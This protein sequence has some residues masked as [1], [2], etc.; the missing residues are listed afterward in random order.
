MTILKDLEAA[1]AHAQRGDVPAATRL[2]RRVLARDKAQP[3]ANYFL[4]RFL[5]EAGDAAASIGHFDR[6]AASRPDDPAIHYHRALALVDL[7]RD[8]EA[9]EA[10]RTVTRLD[11]ASPQ[12]HRD[13]GAALA[14]SGQLAAAVLSLDNCVALDRRDAHALLMLAT[15]NQML[16][17]F[18]AAEA[19][20]GRAIAVEPRRPEAHVAHGNALSALGRLADAQAAFE[21]AL[22]IDPQ[23][24]GALTCLVSIHDD[25]GRFAT[26]IEMGRRVRAMLAPNFTLITR[27]GDAYAHFGDA[28]AAIECYEAAGALPG[29]EPRARAAA[30]S[31][32]LRARL[33]HDRDDAASLAA[34]HRAWDDMHGKPAR[35]FTRPFAN[36][37]A[38]ERRL[39]VGYVSPDFRRHAVSIFFLPFLGAHDRAGFDI[40]CYSDWHR[41][42]ENTETIRGLSNLFR[43]VHAV[44][45]DAL[46]DMIRHDGIDILVDLAGHQPSSRML[47]FASKPAPVQVS[48]LGYP[49]TTGLSAIDWR[50]SDAVCDPPE[51]DALSSE[52]V[53]R[54]P[55]FHA[56]VGPVEDLPV[57]PLPGANGPLTFG[58]FNYLAKLSDTTLR[59]WAR[60]LAAVPGSRL[61]L[62]GS[63]AVDEP[64]RAMYRAR[65]VAAGL[66]EDRFEIVPRSPTVIEHL[67][68]Y[69]KIDIALDPAPYCGTTTTCEALWM[70]VPVL[71]LKGDRHAAR[72]G[73]SLMQQVGLP[74]FVAASADEYVAH[75]VRWAQDR[76]ALAALRAGLR[77]RMQA[78][79]LC[80]VAGLAR[81]VAD[82]YR[83]MWRDWCTRMPG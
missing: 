73:A 83:M 53:L 52:R 76:G 6:A 28:D 20:A 60:V 30:G 67:E 1:A 26:A 70:G 58:S 29:L 75:A 21:R 48:W 33:L 57:S 32:V 13:L 18:A 45:D 46:A 3:D 63:Y 49:G 11:P 54:L 27:L 36:D 5:R 4:G 44:D 78:S 79:P 9:I 42:D 56:Y 68:L 22:A 80:D 82:G 69:G 38:P 12:A 8:A 62:K 47:M 65:F 10:L 7:H 81:N 40:A 14:R 66:P 39:R 23:H 71:T 25:A 77:A 35:L 72:V 61:L 19:A 15:A 37:R 55:G 2:C 74:E 34:A 24:P 17:R 31:A 50:I 16:G 51:D 64:T 59:L 43:H 41:P